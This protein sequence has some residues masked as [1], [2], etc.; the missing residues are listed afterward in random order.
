M[1]ETGKLT[2]IDLF[3]GCG[4]LSLGL[5]NSGKWHGLFAVEKS[6]DAFKTLE[7]NLIN[8]HKHF[9]WPDWLPQSAHDIDNLLTNY[10][11]QLRKLRGKVDLVAGGPPCQG[12][13]LAGRRQEADLRNH[14][15]H[16]YLEFI[17]IVRPNA[18][19]FENVMGFKI[20]FV[21]KETGRG[22]PYSEIV[23][24]QLNDLG[25]TD[26]K[27]EII[28]F[29][30]YGVPQE[31]KRCIIVGT[32]KGNSEDF[33]EDIQSSKEEF[34]RNKNI[35]ATTDLKSAISDIQRKNGEL[36]TEEF[37][38]FTFGKYAR[39]GLTRYQRLMREQPTKLPDSHRFARHTPD[40]EAKFKTVIECKL[41][42]LEIQQIFNTKKCSTK[43]L[44]PNKPAP[45]LT[46][47]PDDYVHYSEP[48]ILTVREYARVQSFP[49][50]YVFK[51]KYTTGGPRRKLEVP[52]YSQIG[53]AIPPLFAEQAGTTLKAII[54][55]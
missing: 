20:G 24:K 43:L 55:E 2:Y 5:Y 38:Q 25:Y 37:K 40:V 52:R 7:H 9:S 4:G 47:L 28:N 44:E 1:Q 3:A 46:T 12:F 8:T 53:N 10:E 45:T 26:A 39:G 17:K 21:N 48:R 33:Y 54:H 35:S 36:R 29:S 14:L 49:D 11:K 19:L 42:S 50:W 13:S 34:L 51:G 27:A 16:S 31:R 18:I 30:E 32:L 15:V 22:V 41:T 6:E 23:L